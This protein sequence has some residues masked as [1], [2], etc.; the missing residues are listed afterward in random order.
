MLLLDNCKVE[1]FFSKDLIELRCDVFLGR[2]IDRQIIAVH[3]RIV[4]GRTIP[5]PANRWIELR[6]NVSVC[7]WNVDHNR[8]KHDNCDNLN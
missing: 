8:G 1:A 3:H 7:K 4:F 2:Q 6:A 5:V